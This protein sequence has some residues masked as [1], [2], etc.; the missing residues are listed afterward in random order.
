M[1]IFNQDTKT[2]LSDD[3]I[4]KIIDKSIDIHDIKQKLVRDLDGTEI[5]KEISQSLKNIKLQND[6][7]IGE[8][9]TR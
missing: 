5:L 1:G 7:I 8:D 2:S 6:E 4:E 3:T 9:I